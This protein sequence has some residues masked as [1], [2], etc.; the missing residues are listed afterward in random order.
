MIRIVSYIFLLTLLSTTVSFGQKK[1][2][3]SLYNYTVIIPDSLIETTDPGNDSEKTYFDDVSGIVLMIT[4]RDGIY[5]NSNSYMNC[6]KKD[7]ER[8]LKDYQGDSTLKLISCSKSKY[9]TAEAVTL[10][11]ETHVLPQGFNRCLI[12]FIHHKNK[13]IQFS[14]MYDKADIN[15]SIA[16][17]DG[18]MHTLKLF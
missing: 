16:Y 11:F 7:L 6:S 17:I 3:S 5:D 4:G 15:S 12:Y 8:Q 10:Q 13:E 18:I 14:F 9:Y 1:L 2:N